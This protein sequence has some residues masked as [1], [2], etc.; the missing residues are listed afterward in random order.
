MLNADCGG[1]GSAIVTLFL[2][3]WIVSVTTYRYKRCDDAGGAPH[4]AWWK[5]ILGAPRALVPGCYAPPA[6]MSRRVP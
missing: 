1:L 4:R 5:P 6:I 2:A 3:S